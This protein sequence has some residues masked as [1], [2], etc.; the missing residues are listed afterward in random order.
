[1][2]DLDALVAQ[3]RT[4][5]TKLVLLVGPQA[6]C[7]AVLDAYAQQRDAPIVSVGAELAR[8][9]TVV[10]KIYR[11]I[12]AARIFRDLIETGAKDDVVLLAN[13]EI[14]FDR[15]LGLNPLLLMRQSARRETAVAIWPGT[16]RNG[17]LIYA[18]VGHGEHQ[19]IE[20]NG[21]QLAEVA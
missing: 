19:D 6:R 11:S 5:Q 1:M 16:L 4:T 13:I 2:L 21:I 18:T 20:P 14:L 3:M 9:L 7:R 15:S 17:R 8:R 10:A 12:E